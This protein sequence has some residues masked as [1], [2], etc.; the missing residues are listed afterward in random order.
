MASALPDI[1]DLQF[2]AC[3]TLDY[4]KHRSQII[5][6]MTG[7]EQGQTHATCNFRPTCWLLQTEDRV[8]I[9]SRG[10]PLENNATP[11]VSMLTE[12]LMF[13]ACREIKKGWCFL[14]AEVSA[15]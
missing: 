2:E 14:P 13:P 4:L 11:G 9:T 8:T 1:H 15:S 12:G 10:I 7:K 5:A 3:G 6:F